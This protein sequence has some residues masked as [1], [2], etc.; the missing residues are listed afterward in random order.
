MPF[1]ALPS[2]PSGSCMGAGSQSEHQGSRNRSTAVSLCCP[3][4]RSLV[5]VGASAA[6]EQSARLGEEGEH[7]CSRML[8]SLEVFS[9]SAAVTPELPG[10]RK[11]KLISNTVDAHVAGDAP[12]SQ[13]CTA[14]AVKLLG[15]LFS[16]TGWLGPHIPSFNTK[17]ENDEPTHAPIYNAQV[18]VVPHK[19]NVASQFR[20]PWGNSDGLRGG[21]GGQHVLQGLVDLL[22]GPLA[23]WLSG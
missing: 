23:F 11:T 4:K 19:E 13:S 1:L 6:W 16:Q 14:G 5:W 20:L 8:V 15:K 2:P 21:G 12:V 7:W 10:G 3:E 17:N 9:V 18:C 22:N